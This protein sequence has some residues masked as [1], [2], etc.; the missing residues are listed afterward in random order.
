MIGKTLSHFEITEE[1]GSG[2]MGEVYRAQDTK[3]G[4]EVALKVLPI[5]LSADPEKVA[6]FEREARM[7]A[8]LNHPSI[9]GIY[10]VGEHEGRM[11][12][13]MEL[14]PG[15]TLKAR[16]EE[17]PLTAGA[18]LWIAFQIAEALEAAHE[19]GIIH[20]DLK[21]GN[22]MVSAQGE[23]KLLDFGLA[24]ALAPDPVS[25]SSLLTDSPTLTSDMLRG[26]ALGTAAYMSPELGTSAAR[27]EGL[28]GASRAVG[29]DGITRMDSRMSDAPEALR[30]A[31]LR[32]ASTLA[33]SRCT[34]R[35]RISSVIGT[36][37]SR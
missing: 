21:P 35:F 30:Q 25:D 8:S 5:A 37:F 23:V 28:R 36:S 2:G 22:V 26:G 12:L 14:A 7:L 6:R 18:T 13:A 15:R 1:L 32:A 31:T 29:T 10:E 9:A 11:F 17:G 19:R 33:S 34:P 24:K 16:L 4:R 20:R 3:L 27:R